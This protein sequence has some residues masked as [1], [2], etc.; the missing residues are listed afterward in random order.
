MNS[1]RA[2]IISLSTLLFV[3][4]N[5]S[6]DTLAVS[7]GQ[8][9]VIENFESEFVP[10]RD[11]FVWL[12]DNFAEDRHYAVLYM[13]DGDMLFDASTTWNDQEWGV[14]EAA[15]GLMAEDVARDF[16]VVGIPNAGPD[17]HIEYFPQKPFEAMSDH[18]QKAFYNMGR[19][20]NGQIFTGEV[21]S[22]KYLRFLVE[23]LKPY[24]DENFPVLSDRDNTFV[25]GSSMGGLIS[26]YAI[27]EYPG[28]FG[29]AACLS[30]HWP[31]VF[32]NE[33][34]PFPLR[35]REYL[36][37]HLPSPDTH[38]IWF[39]HGTEGLDAMY[40]ELQV[41][42]D[43]VMRERGYDA[44]NWVTFVDEGANHSEDA[45]RSR[46]DRPLTFLLA[47]RE[48]DS[49]ASLSSPSRNHRFFFGHR[50]FRCT[51]IQRKT[52]RRNRGG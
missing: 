21:R 22:D 28:V 33:N 2:L 45:W 52:W 40:P 16:I 5:I 29:G 51:A 11:V 17:R 8:V 41:Q 31:G 14:D 15:S 48:G 42:V 38:R 13:H 35:T 3:A 34:N 18:Q 39:D 20:N 1:C 32:S 24:I 9:V 46:L 37:D 7:A 10:A 4:A 6:A 12:P 26:I 19:E 47:P 23:E 25:M 43:A 49:L 44:G 50:S 30:T 36:A 27:S